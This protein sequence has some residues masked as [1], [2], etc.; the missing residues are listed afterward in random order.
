MT[1]DLD[2]PAYTKVDK[3]RENHEEEKK[4]VAKYKQLLCLERLLGPKAIYAVM[5]GAK[6]VLDNEISK[7]EMEFCQESV[8]NKRQAIATRKH[9]K[10]MS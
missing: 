8:H 1:E 5:L 2:G 7:L 9:W 4:S 3:R 6:D 10:R